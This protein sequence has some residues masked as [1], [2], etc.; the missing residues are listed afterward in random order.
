MGGGVEVGVFVNPGV[1]PVIGPTVGTKPSLDGLG[2]T[3]GYGV[4]MH[5][6][7]KSVVGDFTLGLRRIDFG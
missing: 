5:Q 4:S 6:Q 7:R 2:S 3:T 1:I